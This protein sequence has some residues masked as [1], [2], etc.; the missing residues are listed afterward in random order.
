MAIDD[1]TGACG[2]L[3]PVYDASGAATA[4]CPSRWRP[5]WPHDTDGTI[6]AAR[7]LHERIDLPNLM[8]KIPATAEG[9]PAI[10]PDDHRGA[11]HQR[12]P[13]LQPGPLRRGDRGLHVRP[14]GLGRRRRRPEPGPQRG[15]V[16][17]QPGRHRGRPPPGQASAT[18]A[19]RCR[20]RP[21]W[22]RPS[23]P[24]SSSRSASPA[25]AGRRWRAKGAHVQRP[26]WASTSTKNPAYPDLLYVDSLIGPDTVNTMPDATVAAFLDHGTVRPHR[27]RRR[28]RG[29]GPSRPPGRRRHRHGRRGPARSRTKGW[30]SFAKSFDELLQSL[31]GQGQ[32]P[33]NPASVSG[34]LTPVATRRHR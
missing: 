12:H 23:W 22:P 16:L 8:V 32:R 24:T 26:L 25:P 10:Q 20:A 15:V 4:S 11:Q 3:R 31:H 14:G 5:R 27:R 28:R 7:S 6:E 2:I 9:V 30:P 13:D 34:L 33:R 21:R 29:P 18:R 17:R 1:V 19:R